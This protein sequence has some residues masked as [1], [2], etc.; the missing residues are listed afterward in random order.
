M[1]TT[2]G[3]TIFSRSVTALT[4]RLACALRIRLVELVALTLLELYAVGERVVGSFVFRL[5]RALPIRASLPREH[6]FR[7]GTAFA[8]VTQQRPLESKWDTV[9]CPFFCEASAFK[10]EWKIR[11]HKTE[12]RKPVTHTNTA[13]LQI[14]FRNDEPRREGQHSSTWHLYSRDREERKVFVSC[15]GVSRPRIVGKEAA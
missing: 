9:S 14:I 11:F 8:I 3:H 6:P 10:G 15:D 5:L 7:V 2:P 12:R 4:A 13:G 1:L